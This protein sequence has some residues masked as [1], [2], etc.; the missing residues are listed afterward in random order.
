MQPYFSLARWALPV[1]TAAALSAC[2]G[3]DNATPRYTN[4]VSFGDS[5][6]DVGSY[7]VG[8]IAALGGGKF[9]VNGPSGLNWT[10]HLVQR[11]DVAAPCAAQTGLSPNVAGLVGAPIT[12][13]PGCHNYAQGGARVTSPLGPHSAA[14]QGAPFYANTIGT[15]ATPVQVQMTTHLL[16]SGGSFNGSELVTV[17]AG[18]NDVFMNLNAVA[19]AAQ[20]G[21]AAVG[22]ALAAGWGEAVQAAVAAGGAGAVDAART[23]AVQNMAQAGG[24]LAALVRQQLLGKGA[25][26]VLVANIPDVGNTPLALQRGAATRQLATALATTFNAQLQTGLKDAPIVWADVFAQG[27]EQVATPAR[28]GLTNLTD[29]ACSTNPALNPLE[30][31]SLACTERSTSAPNTDGYLYADDVH[32]TPRGYRLIADYLAERLERAGWL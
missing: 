30:G 4:L 20:G 6:S 31:N 26:Y 13:V 8:S 32:P 14:L 21:D 9:T 25:R 16:R 27:R 11:L 28:F 15:M 24:T 17:M 1:L 2:G 7:R 19:A 23:A 22:A 18:A 10:E 3:S 12:S 29:M 5:L